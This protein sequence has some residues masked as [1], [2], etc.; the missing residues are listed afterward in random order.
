MTMQR[1]RDELSSGATVQSL[2]AAGN[3]SSSVYMA[4]KQ[5]KKGG[6]RKSS[7]HSAVPRRSGGGSQPPAAGPGESSDRLVDLRRETAEIQAEN[8]LAKAR[9]ESERLRGPSVV[10]DPLQELAVVALK[11]ELLAGVAG[12]GGPVKSNPLAD[13]RALLELIT[14]IHGTAGPS[15]GTT[16]AEMLYGVEKVKS[17][18]VREQARDAHQ[19]AESERKDRLQAQIFES[20]SRAMPAL[21]KMFV[22]R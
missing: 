12:A 20:A 1:L 2:I 16:A 13:A 11:R 18:L 9:A 17:D 8:A 14:I 4:A 10:G 22:S 6:T 15:G 19:R 3:S 7:A 5:L 21:F